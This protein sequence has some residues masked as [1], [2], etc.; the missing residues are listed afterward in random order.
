[1]SRNDRKWTLWQK[2]QDRHRKSS[3]I[4]VCSVEIFVK[5]YDSLGKLSRRQI[6]T[7]FKRSSA[8]C[9]TQHA[10]RLSGKIKT[11]IRLREYTGWTQYSLSA[12]DTFVLKQILQL[13]SSREAVISIFDLILFFLLWNTNIFENQWISSLFWSAS[14]N[15]SITLYKWACSDDVTNNVQEIKPTI[16]MKFSTIRYLITW[17]AILMLLMLLSFSVTSRIYSHIYSEK[18]ESLLFSSLRL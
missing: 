13:H 9:V 12:Q 10:K 8:D 2:R 17:L 5:L 16:K 3:L 14:S 11:L 7:S 18:A 6:N 1:M 15:N 4:R